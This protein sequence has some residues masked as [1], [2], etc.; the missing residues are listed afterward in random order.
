MKELFK[1]D[2]SFL[3]LLLCLAGTIFYFLFELIGLYNTTTDLW[4]NGFRYAFISEYGYRDYSNILFF[5]YRI[6]D[7][8]SIVSI[9]YLIFLLIKY[10]HVLFERI[11]LTHTCSWYS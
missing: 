1:R 9:T 5:F 2:N 3:L 6:V 7:F 8:L 4:L 11:C 10:K